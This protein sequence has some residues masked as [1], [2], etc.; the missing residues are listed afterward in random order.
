MNTTKEEIIT[1][2][3][4]PGKDIDI[5]HYYSSAMKEKWW[6]LVLIPFIDVLSITISRE[7]AKAFKAWLRRD[8]SVA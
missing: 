6:G 7:K 3:A 4:A 1:A 2:T 5:R 8:G